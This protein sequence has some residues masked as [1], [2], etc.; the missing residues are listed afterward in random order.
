M[1]DKDTYIPSKEDMQKLIKAF[2]SVHVDNRKDDIGPNKPDAPFFMRMA[3]ADIIDEEDYI[4]MA[5]RFY[6]YRLTQLP[7]IQH[8]AG[9]PPST[10]WDEALL[11]LK[12]LGQKAKVAN[13]LRRVKVQNF[14]AMFDTSKIHWDAVK[15][16][17]YFDPVMMAD[18]VMKAEEN[19]ELYQPILVDVMKNIIKNVKSDVEE[20]TIHCERYK[21]QGKWK[22]ISLRF[23]NKYDV[24]IPFYKCMKH[25]IEDWKDFSWDSGNTCMSVKDDVR[26]IK[27]VIKCIDKIND[28]I[29]NGDK[30]YPREFRQLSSEIRGLYIDKT[31]IDYSNL[32]AMISDADDL[33][34]VKPT[35]YTAKLHKGDVAIYLP[36]NAVDFRNVLK[37]TGNAKF[38]GD[39]KFWT[40][41]LSLVHDVIEELNDYY[42]EDE[43]DDEED[44]IQL[45]YKNKLVN[46]I[47]SI[48]S[49]AEYV[50]AKAERIHL[51]GSVVVDDEDIIESMRS[52]L[53]EIFPA[54]HVLYPFQYTGVR[55]AEIS[56]GRCL[57]GDDMGVGKTIQALAYAALHPEHHPVLV[58]SPA[59]VKFNWLKEAE[60]WVGS[61]YT[62]AVIRKGKDTVPD[63]DI[64]IIN[65]DLVNKQKDALLARGFKTIICDESHYLKSYK[66]ARTKATMEIVKECESV[67]F[68]SGTAMNNR[69]IELWS[70]LCALRPSEWRGRWHEYTE[71][72]CGVEYNSMGYR[73]YNGSS[74]EAELN[75]KL[76]DLM[77]RRLKKEVMAELPDKI[78]QYH[79][80]E[81]T[82]KE[83]NSYHAEQQSV[84]ASI[85]SDKQYNVSNG[86]MRGNN[87]ADA[88]V[89]L[90]HLRHLCGL[91]KVNAAIS[92]VNEYKMNNDK[93]LLVFTHHKD[94][95]DNIYTGLRNQTN[96]PR[97]GLITGDVAAEKR[98]QVVDQFQSGNLDVVLATTPAAKEGLTLTAA[99]TVVFVEREWS[100]SHEEQ[101]EDR[102]NRIGQDAETVWAVYLTVSGS[103]DEKF[104]KVVEEKREVI[105]AVLDGGEIGERNSIVSELLKEMMKDGNR[106]AKEYFYR[107][108]DE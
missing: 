36:Y 55:Y 25:L 64:V 85:V 67:L 83:S 104:N 103:I 16:E 102:V 108:D 71:R 10:N 19:A 68:L 90:T 3:N 106:K 24:G 95:L 96:P 99:D 21:K 54:G 38:D 6:K 26:S 27:N 35:D 58:V 69:P 72:Y 48:E 59:N 22:S 50:N 33:F 53:A 1:I 75:A 44:L 20:K 91:M 70:T 9:F 98:Q 87:G 46:S 107:S 47:M 84:L 60:K 92:Y 43:D 63:T 105:K 56:N 94:V 42:E 51:S 86:G 23:T 2:V 62:S 49:V 37:H 74:N 8:I 14:E 77:I 15:K 31:L 41:S 66:A 29:T 4:E 40:L 80:V 52:R 17:V 32:S 89:A 65:Y 79:Y 12:E 101:A 93:P 88:L 7:V 97:I 100:P 28:M 76:R 39:E 11:M 73:T 18:I 13:Q 57:I 45:A 61:T 78:R 81:L 30:N 82:A 34:A 5:D